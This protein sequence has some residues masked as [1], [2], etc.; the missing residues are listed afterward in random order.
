MKNTVI[1]LALAVLVSLSATAREKYNVYFGNTH[2]HCN[3]SGDIK[4][5]LTKQGK[6]MD[7]LNTVEQHL[8]LAKENGYDFYCITDHSQY[9]EFSAGSW[10]ETKKQADIFTDENFVAMCGYE[11]SE[12]DGPDGRGHMNVFDTPDYLSALAP[13][14]SI[15]YFHNWLALDK[16]D[17]ASVCF[18]HPAIDGYND[19]HCYNESIREKMTMMELVNGMNPKFYPVFLHALSKGWKI[20]P[21]AGCDN[22]SWQGIAKW[23][24]RTGIL[25]EALTYDALTEAMAARRTYATLDGNLSLAY[26]VNGNIMGSEI[27]P[28]KKYGFDIQISDPDTD[29]PT[30]RITKVEI[31]G[32]GGKVIASRQFDSH[33]VKWRTSLAAGAQP[34]YFVLVY[35]AA[36]E[37][38]PVAYAAPVW[39][40]K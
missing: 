1:T 18:N 22:H 38:S 40:A 16:N 12:N 33:D 24:G 34:Y 8:R 4:V 21:V 19:F 23:E 6:P 10:T 20:S 28:A 37:S 31:V 2:A 3:Y 25:A 30:N 35:N 32:E 26:R 14:V 17:V 11:H 9:P 7:P 13:E 27:D 36:R 29:D 5:F 39:I 15:E